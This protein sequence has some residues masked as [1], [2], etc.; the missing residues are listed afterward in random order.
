MSE[1]EKSTIFRV[2]EYAAKKKMAGETFT[3]DDLCVSL[4]LPWNVV[5]RCVAFVWD[6][7]VF[8]GHH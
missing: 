6:M 4:G 7:S 3:G 5:S 8:R 1:M 2:M